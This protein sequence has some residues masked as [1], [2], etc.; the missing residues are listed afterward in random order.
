MATV[1]DL[2]PAQVAFVDLQT[3]RLTPAAIRA[4]RT[5]FDRVGGATG[6]STTDLATADDDDSGL[7]EFKHETGKALQA[8]A[9]APLAQAQVQIE[10][11]QAEINGLREQVAELT[12]HIQGIEQG[13]IYDGNS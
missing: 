5:V 3:G 4:L 10:L 11:L 6:S 12:K 2:F 9:L 1:L 13:A 8:L 7:E